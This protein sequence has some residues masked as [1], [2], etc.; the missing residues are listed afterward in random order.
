MTKIVC[1][2][3]THN[4]HHDVDV[5]DGDILIHAGDFTLAGSLGEVVEFNEWLGTLDHNFKIVVAGNHDRCLGD[6]GTLGLKIFTNAIYL[7]RSGTE[8]MGIKFWGAPMTPAFNGMRGGLTFYTNSKKEAKGVWRGMPKKLDVLIT[9]GPPKFILDG[10][11]RY[12]Y[13]QT[14]P[15]GE[16]NIEHCGDGMLASKVIANKPKYHVF[17]HIHEGYGRFT[18]NYGTKFINC[19]VVNEAYN[20]V[21]KPIVIDL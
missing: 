10:V 9:H 11:E 3:D 21:N 12:G 2:S 15:S 13:G 7:E 6:N 4:Y 19:S 16:K 17:G 1:I 14:F 8:L 18:A 5:P 20:V